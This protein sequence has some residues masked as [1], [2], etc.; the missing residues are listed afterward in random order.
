MLLI[1][2]FSFM[3]LMCFFM[4]TN[5]LAVGSVFHGFT[6]VSIGHVDIPLTS[7][8]SER[9]QK[10]RTCDDRDLLLGSD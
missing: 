4:K 2:C 6:E 3:P 10:K 5:V 9:L 8:L 1:I 7:L